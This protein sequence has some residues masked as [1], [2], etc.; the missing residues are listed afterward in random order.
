MQY[1]YNVL[2]TID[3][4]FNVIVLGGDPD[5]SISSHCALALHIE[6]T[7]KGKAKKLV[8]PFAR[9]IDFLFDNKLY[10]IEKNHILNSHEPSED[11][12]KAIWKWYTLEEKNG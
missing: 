5:V 2:L 12:H 9:F 11:N 4:S 1:L 8:R 6:D 10:T 7:G 3:Q